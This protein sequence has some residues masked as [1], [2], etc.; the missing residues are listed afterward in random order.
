MKLFALITLL[1]S[2]FAQLALRALFITLVYYGLFQN[3]YH[4]I[5]QYLFV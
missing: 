4:I 5:L 3:F 2:F 1:D